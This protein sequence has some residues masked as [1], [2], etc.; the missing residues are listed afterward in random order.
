MRAQGV[1][2]PCNLLR[3]RKSASG[4]MSTARG[5]LMD[6]TNCRPACSSNFAFTCLGHNEAQ[7][8]NHDLPSKQA[9]QS[10][11][12]SVAPNRT[13]THTLAYIHTHTGQPDEACNCP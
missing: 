11:A 7:S 2:L 10:A 12:S 3:S 6:L 4:N 13:H 9:W 5:S 8:H 1:L